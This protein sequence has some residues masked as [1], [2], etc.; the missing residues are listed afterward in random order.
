[1]SNDKDVKRILKGT[2]GL[3]E[4]TQGRTNLGQGRLP[5]GWDS[6]LV[7]EGTVA[8]YLIAEKFT[9]LFGPELVHSGQAGGNSP[10]WC[11]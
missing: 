5:G 6:D 2:P 10:L 3:R 9:G 11:R 7:G 4:S 8:A 1:M